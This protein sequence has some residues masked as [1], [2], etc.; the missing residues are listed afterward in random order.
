MV[1]V[2]SLHYFITLHKEFATVKPR[3]EGFQGLKHSDPLLQESITANIELKRK[4]G[5]ETKGKSAFLRYSTT[6]GSVIAGF[7]VLIFE[8]LSIINRYC[9]N[10]IEL[11][12][13]LKGLDGM[14][15][16]RIPL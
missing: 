7:T 10:Q 13:N 11:R 12:Q 8:L 3:N 14:S 1:R 16:A 6:L 5:Q 2:A 9:Q 4:R 15:A